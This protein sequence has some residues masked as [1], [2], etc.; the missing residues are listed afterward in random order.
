MHTSGKFANGAVSGAFV[1]LFNAERIAKARQKILQL[2]IDKIIASFEKMRNLPL[3][4]R[5]M[6]LYPKLCI[7][8]LQIST[9]HLPIGTSLN[10][11]NYQTGSPAKFIKIPIAKH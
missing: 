1:H 7:R 2:S 3:A 8:N 6:L 9:N 4:Q 10:F 5:L 11:L